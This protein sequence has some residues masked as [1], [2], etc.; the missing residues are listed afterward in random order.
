MDLIRDWV[1][2]VEFWLELQGWVGVKF[3]WG[4]DESKLGHGY[5]IVQ[6]PEKQTPF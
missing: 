4:E 2:E 6:G 5:L 1:K 3:C